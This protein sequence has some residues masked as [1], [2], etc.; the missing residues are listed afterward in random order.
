MIVSRGTEP[1]HSS[2]S[3]SD[4]V[5]FRHDPSLFHPSH[6]Y[7]SEESVLGFIEA[8]TAPCL[9]LQAEKGWPVQSVSDIER[10]K[11]ILRRKKLFDY[12]LMV[13]IYPK[14]LHT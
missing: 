11:D 3:K 1:F 12:D 4:S 7:A 2:E 13:R 9:F 8:I 6:V 10:R 5:K 14:Y